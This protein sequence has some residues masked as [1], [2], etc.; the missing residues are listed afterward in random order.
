M[1]LRSLAGGTA[2]RLDIVGDTDAAQK[3]LLRCRAAPLGKAAPVA[4]SERLVHDLLVGAAVIRQSQRV[5][6]W[7][8][9]CRHEIAPPQVQAIEGG[10][11]RR[12]RRQASD[13]ETPLS[14]TCAE[15]G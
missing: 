12:D 13:T 2:G 3:T 11:S 6:V 14:P 10:A 8:G 5:G 15:I 4:G 9:R 1:N 7:H